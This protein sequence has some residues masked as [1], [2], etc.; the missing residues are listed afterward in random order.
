MIQLV[1]EC[2]LSFNFNVLT[3]ILFT[4]LVWFKYRIINQINYT[5][6]LYIYIYISIQVSQNSLRFSTPIMTWLHSQYLERILLYLL[7]IYPD[8]GPR[9]LQNKYQSYIMWKFYIMCFPLLV[10]SFLIRMK[11]RRKKKSMSKGHKE[12]KMSNWSD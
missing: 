8:Y 5:E 12:D 2:Q 4:L 9:S 10:F 3:D 1:R 11:K 7:N 6:R